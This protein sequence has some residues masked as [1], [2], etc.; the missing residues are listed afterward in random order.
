ML[1]VNPIWEQPLLPH[2][3]LLIAGRKLAVQGPGRPA[4]SRGMLC[5]PSLQLK[6]P[7]LVNTTH[8]RA[9]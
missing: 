6:L 7:V 8:L 9:T 3:D 5:Y 2:A 1:V 4:G